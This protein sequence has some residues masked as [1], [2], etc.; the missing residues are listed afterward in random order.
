MVNLYNRTLLS[1]KSYVL[2]VHAK[3]WIHLRSTELTAYKSIYNVYE[4]P[5]AV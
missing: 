1:N 3:T 5:Y 4:V 2:F